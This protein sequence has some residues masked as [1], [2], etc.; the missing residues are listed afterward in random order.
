MKKVLSFTHLSRQFAF[1]LLALVP[2]SC[3]PPVVVAEPFQNENVPE[4][5]GEPVLLNL[6]GYFLLHEE[7]ISPFIRDG[8]VY[9]PLYDFGGLL[10]SEAIYDYVNGFEEPPLSAL[11]LKNNMA[12]KINNESV[13]SII[14]TDTNETISPS[15]SGNED[16]WLEVDDTFY[17]VYVPLN[18]FVDAFGIDVSYNNKTQ[19]F[20]ISTVHPDS[21]FAR[22]LKDNEI[23]LYDLQ[24]TPI[25]KP[26]KV[27]V[28]IIEEATPHM[29]A[30]LELTLEIQALTKNEIAAE[31][32]SVALLAFYE[33]AG[34]SFSGDTTIKSFTC[35]T[36][37]EE[38]HF[39]CTEVFI[40]PG[41]PDGGLYRGR[42]RYFFSHMGVRVD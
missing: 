5:L 2:L 10:A 34:V 21:S 23:L 41:G 36:L 40:A 11:L 12:L 35:E 38:N 6:N 31:D 1:F 4:S 33:G 25:V 22:L 17:G 26:T 39:R 18:I 8:Q 19:A 7:P 9:V 42:F 30:T 29:D 14:N 28:E 32:I 13:I 24:A 37:R 27:K 15:Y 20:D 3:T 16:I